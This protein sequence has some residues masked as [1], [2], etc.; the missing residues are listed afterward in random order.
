MIPGVYIKNNNQ[1]QQKSHKCWHKY[2]L[3][4]NIWQAE[5]RKPYVQKYIYIYSIHD[6]A[7]D[8]DNEDELTF[9]SQ[10]SPKNR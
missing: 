8:N 9:W 10:S 3:N 7:N 2:S 5:Y 4:L 6:G 1:Y